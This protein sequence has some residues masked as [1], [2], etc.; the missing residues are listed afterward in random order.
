MTMPAGSEVYTTDAGPVRARGVSINEDE[1]QTAL[2]ARVASI[3]WDE[4]GTAEMKALLDGIATTQF[5]EERLRSVISSS[6]DPEDWRVGEALAEAYLCDHRNCEFP[7]P[8]GRDLK[9][10]KASPAGTDLVGFQASVDDNG[11]RFAFAEVKTSQEGKWPPS[12][13]KGRHGLSQQLEALRDS[14]P[15]KAYLVKYLGHHAAHTPW[16]YRYKAAAKRYLCDTTDV[17]LFGLL[18]RDVEPKE[19]DLK[20]RAEVLADKCPEATS[21]ELQAMYLPIGCISTLPNRTKAA[22]EALG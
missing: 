16:R 18:V 21:I 1:L 14:E 9:N 8:G 5:E 10:P 17:S 15:T 13:M 6:P 11:A 22:K 20:R 19:A 12:V 3:V 4:A 7:W 2:T